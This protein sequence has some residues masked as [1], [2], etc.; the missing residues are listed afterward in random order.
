MANTYLPVLLSLKNRACL[1][2]GGGQVA[3]RKVDT[4]LDYNGKI[5][6]IAPEPVNKIQYYAERGFLQLEKREYHSPEAANYG[7]VISASDDSEINKS[8]YEDCHAAGVPVN[9][10]DNPPLCDFIFPAILKRNCLTIAIA[11][12]G[13]APFLS[14]HLRYVLENIFPERWNK[15]A[16]IAAHFRNKVQ[17]QWAGKPEQKKAAFERFVEADW[18]TILENK[19]EE[20]VEAEIT[21][22][23]HGE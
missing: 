13:K 10:V 6:V 18:K 20:A 16:N 21:R 4:L 5:T 14:G 15:L 7:L 17:E 8:V 3:L 9:V 12:D 2:V 19:N 1:V 22:L 11:T 23:L